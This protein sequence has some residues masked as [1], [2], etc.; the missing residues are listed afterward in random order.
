M[1]I[2]VHLPK[3]GGTSIREIMRNHFKEHEFRCFYDQQHNK[4]STVR[5]SLSRNLKFV[6]GHNDADAFDEI[7]PN[8]KKIT[9][10]R[11]PVQR[12]ISLYNHIISRKFIENNPDAQYVIDHKLHFE[13]FIK[14]KWTHNYSMR[15]IKNLPVES[16][17]HIGFCEYFQKSLDNLSRRLK[18]K[19][20]LI[21]TWENKTNIKSYQLT[22]SLISEIREH[23]AKEYEFYNKAINIFLD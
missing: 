21:Q 11:D 2:F 17:F 12:T 7:Y 5:L 19:K 20:N 13:D 8:S 15:F 3:C 9:W 6:C 18:F 4:A 1:I 14:L 10:M 16:F 22:N 23:N